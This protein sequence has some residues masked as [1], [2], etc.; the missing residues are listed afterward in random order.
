M[1][2]K[3]HMNEQELQKLRDDNDAQKTW[4]K[5]VH[6]AHRNTKEHGVSFSSSFTSS[7]NARKDEESNQQQQ[8]TTPMDQDN[9]NVSKRKQQQIQQQKRDQIK[10]QDS[11]KLSF[12][13]DDEE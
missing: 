2:D 3:K 10:K 13:M 5:V 11:S 7:S 9:N 1:D 12:N 8:Q 6:K 4:K